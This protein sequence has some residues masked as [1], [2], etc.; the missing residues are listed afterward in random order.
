MKLQQSGCAGESPLGKKRQGIPVDRI[1]EDFA[2]VRGAAMAIEA[3]HEMRAQA[4]EQQTRQGHI[5]HLSFDDE[6]ELR[7]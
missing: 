5:V 7:G 6:G 4:P 3:L 1:S 2:G